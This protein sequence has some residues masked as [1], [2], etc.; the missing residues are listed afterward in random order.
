MLRILG[1]DNGLAAVMFNVKNFAMLSGFVFAVVM[2]LI[3]KEH[4]VDSHLTSERVLE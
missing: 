4:P 2:H 1:A 3:I